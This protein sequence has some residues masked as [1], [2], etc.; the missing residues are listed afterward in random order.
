MQDSNPRPTGWKPGMPPNNTYHAKS[1]RRDLN[2][3]GHIAARV[4]D[5]AATRL[6]GYTPRIVLSGIEPDSTPHIRR[7]RTTS[8][9]RTLSYIKDSNFAQRRYQ[10]PPGNPPCMYGMVKVGIEPTTRMAS[11]SRS[12]T[13]LLNL[14]ERRL[15][16]FAYDTLYTGLTSVGFE[17][18]YTAV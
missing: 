11:T 16:H 18:T 15:T 13:E 3:Q 6:R 8:P 7:L 14:K 9:L 2:S 1:E 17:P 10:H 4:Q 5:G 12:T